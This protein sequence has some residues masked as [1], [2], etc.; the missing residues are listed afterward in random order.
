MFEDRSRAE[1][2]GAVA[3]LYDRAR[4]TYPPALVDALLTG[5]ARTV[6]DVGCGTGIAGA[7]VAT[8]GC[9]VLGVEIDPRM[10]EVARSKGLEVEIA[11]FESWDDRGR[12]FDLM[13]CAQAWHWINPRAGAGKAAEVLAAGAGIALFWNFGHPPGHVHER[14]DPIYR[15]LEPDLRTS[16]VIFGDP[17]SRIEVTET[18]LLESG[19]FNA[20]AVRRFPW[21][22][23]YSTETWLENLSTQSNHQALSEPRL[24]ELLAAVREAIDGV[25][26]TFEMSYETL[27]VQATRR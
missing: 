16:S 17:G 26:G 2:F 1:S 25:G 10:A 21:S 3:R 22:K 27:L 23:R 15:R 13:I 12:R 19:R 6:L 11:S 9:E 7:L 8:R 4:P 5:G 14:L 24:H 18:G 20:I